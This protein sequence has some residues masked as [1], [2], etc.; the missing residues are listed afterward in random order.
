VYF[1][2]V[3]KILFS[4]FDKSFLAKDRDN[5]RLTVAYFISIFSWI[6]WVKD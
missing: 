4:V 3:I 1:A 2:D 6:G 5:F